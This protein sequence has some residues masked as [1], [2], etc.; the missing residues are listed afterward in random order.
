MDVPLAS[1]AKTLLSSAAYLR[2]QFPDGR[3]LRDEPTG[4]SPLPLQECR[5]F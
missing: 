1:R 4:L 3:G 2:D 5:R